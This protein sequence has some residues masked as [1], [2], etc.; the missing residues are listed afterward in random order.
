M[1]FKNELSII[2]CGGLVMLLTFFAQKVMQIHLSDALVLGLNFVGI[3]FIF[4]GM[5]LTLLKYYRMYI[6]M[7]NKKDKQIFFIYAIEDFDR[8]HSI[9]SFLKQNGYKP[10]LDQLDLLP[11]Q[12]TS[13]V[14]KNELTRSKIVFV[15]ISKYVS[16]NDS[17]ILEEIRLSL[18][19]LPSPYR[20]FSPVI[21]IRLDDVEITI[22][23]L[24]HIQSVDLYKY[25]NLSKLLD[26]LDI[27]HIGKEL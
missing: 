3:F 22:D 4:M 2:A 6:N 9:Y 18:K 24:K 5:L 20:G 23:E 11:G 14:I 27:W 16:V 7:R 12:N 25:Q 1:N 19:S 21:P 26:S 13:E 17:N 10:W 8:V 15:F